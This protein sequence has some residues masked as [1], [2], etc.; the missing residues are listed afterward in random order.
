MKLRPVINLLL[1]ASVPRLALAG[2]EA[3]V[4][5]RGSAR[6]EA[7]ASV[8]ASG[9]EL[10]GKLV[11]D[12]G[13]A[14]PDAHVRVR[15]HTDSGPRP[16]P[17]PFACGAPAPRNGLP[18]EAGDEALAGS[19]G[20]G[21]FCVR[22]P[23]QLSGGHLALEFEDEHHLLDP[24]STVVELDHRP[25]LELAFAPPP[26]LLSAEDEELTVV[27]QAK[28]SD[29]STQR[30]NVT[31]EL[32]R[33]GAKPTL[34]AQGELRPDEA[35]RLSFAPRGL[36]APG[37]G[38]LI[39]EAHI[40]SRSVQ[41]RAPVSVTAK[42]TLDVPTAI[43]ANADGEAWLD[44]KVRSVF[45]AVPSGSVEAV[46]AGRTA[47]IASVTRGAARVPLHLP[48]APGQSTITVRYLSAAPWWLPGGGEEV[49]VMVLRGAPWKWLPWGA[50]LLAVAAWVLLA[51]RRPE[52]NE[53]RAAPP[54]AMK[55]IRPEIEWL[56]ASDGKLS[57]WAGR[58]L[59]AHDGHGIAGAR[60]RIAWPHGGVL[61][62]DADSAGAFR[63]E[64]D[65]AVAQGGVISVE[66][67]WHARLERPLPP[68]GSL[69][70]SLV[71]RRR[72][73]LARFVE[74]TEQR[75]PKLGPGEPTPAELARAA[76][77][78]HPDIAAWA[79]AVESA[80]FG[81]NPVDAEREAEVDAQKPQS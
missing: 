44:V 47:G 66:S 28:G 29:G 6:I 74:W 19:D 9:T 1:L 14:I 79:A 49:A 81:P 75:R 80:A 13:R 78:H 72:A 41:A 21:R 7:T 65:G 58:V 55:P 70:V 31:L 25:A 57:G 12:S 35:L 4:R 2:P 73:L 39:A 32:K 22:W 15:W 67:P 5:V 69:T 11:D 56:S 36:G 43:E 30:G 8:S 60:V 18:S 76:G 42:V 46:L 50:G 33:V 51:W 24:T 62:S 26:R 71:T 27:L 54:P 59:D 20:N 34:L 40:G 52:R 23:L 68:P 77:A 48:P 61:E 10:A 17:R 37:P 64:Y 16:L 53:L 3:R 45:G 63:I 38:E